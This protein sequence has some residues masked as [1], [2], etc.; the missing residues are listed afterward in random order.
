M[1]NKYVLYR[2]SFINAPFVHAVY[3]KVSGLKGK[4]SKRTMCGENMMRWR[5]SYIIFVYVLKFIVGNNVNKREIFKRIL[6][7]DTT[8]NQEDGVLFIYWGRMD[9]NAQISNIYYVSWF[10][11]ICTYIFTRKLQVLNADFDKTWW[12][13][14][15]CL[16]MQRKFIFLDR[17]SLVQ[18]LLNFMLICQFECESFKLY[19]CGN[20][21]ILVV[22]LFVFDYY[23]F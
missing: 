13:C 11:T 7:R 18:R 15:L 23:A 19:F 22:I 3:F 9:V 16:D 14:K 21:I 5:L 2:T 4:K 20:L 6:K 1:K 8:E 17:N 10:T 12:G